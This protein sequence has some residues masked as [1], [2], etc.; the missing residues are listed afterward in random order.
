[1]SLKCYKCENFVVDASELE[2]EIKGLNIVSSAYGSVRADTGLCLWH[3]TFV[4][5]SS[6]CDDFIKK[7][8]SYKI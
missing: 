8:F 2:R 6:S 1:M 4:T 3:E 7:T 5:N